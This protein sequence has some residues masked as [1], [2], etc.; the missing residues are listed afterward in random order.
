MIAVYITGLIVI[1]I[2]VICVAVTAVTMMRM[3]SAERKDL[4]TRIQCRDAIEYK[5]VTNDT[6]RVMP[7]SDEEQAIDDWVGDY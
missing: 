2:A 3:Q 1:A 5:H 6:P 4:Y 7:V